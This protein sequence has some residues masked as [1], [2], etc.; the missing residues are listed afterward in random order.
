MSEFVGCFLS[1]TISVA[2]DIASEPGKVNRLLNHMTLHCHLT[3]REI[4][5]RIE[6]WFWV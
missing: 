1:E 5:M 2:K 4:E 6:W 3:G